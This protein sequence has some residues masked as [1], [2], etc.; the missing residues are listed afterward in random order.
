MLLALVL[1]IVCVGVAQGRSAKVATGLTGAPGEGT[2]AD[3]HEPADDG[4]GSI[5]VTVP[6]YYA[7]GETLEVCVDV[8]HLG[9]VRW[10]F[11]LTCL[12]GFGQPTG[13]FILTDT[14][15]T[16]L[17]VDDRT[18]REYVMHTADGTDEGC[19]NA[20]LTWSCRWVAPADHWPQINF[21]ASAVA[22]N[23]TAG[24]N[25]DYVYTVG[26]PIDQT[27]VEDATWGRLKSLF[28]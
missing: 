26:L 14:E 13:H 23:G 20:C 9:Q 10:G 16:Q 15:R 22:A 18:G 7:P 4:G 8:E 3:C 25:G 24:K 28:R 19:A 2:C 6:Y 1:L 5:C 17:A 21:Y 11:E 27:P 12:D